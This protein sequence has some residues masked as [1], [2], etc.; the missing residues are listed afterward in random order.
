MSDV[1][2]R[3]DRARIVRQDTHCIKHVKD[4]IHF[5]RDDGGGPNL[6]LASSDGIETRA[7]FLGNYVQYDTAAHG[8]AS[9]S[10]TNP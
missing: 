4:F 6:R 8:V 5:I 1:D 7:R 10:T 2:A 3:Y 9:V